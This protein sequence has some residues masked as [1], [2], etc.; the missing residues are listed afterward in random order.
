MTII[1]THPAAEELR[2][3][4]DRLGLSRT[5]LAHLAGCSLSSL[6]NIENGYVPKQSDVLSRARAV[7]ADLERQ[8]AR[9]GA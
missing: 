4:R 2:A 3:R 7:L 6:C 8:R 5:R 9:A 1:N